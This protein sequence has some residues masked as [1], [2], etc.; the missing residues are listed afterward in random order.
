MNE[1]RAVKT[2]M[3]LEKTFDFVIPI[4]LTAKA[5]RIKAAHEANTDSSIIGLNIPK[6]N[7]V[8]MKSLEVEDNE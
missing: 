7:R 1:K 2:G 3:Q 5:K 8:F 6:V 4:F